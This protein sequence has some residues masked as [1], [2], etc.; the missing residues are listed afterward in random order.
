[1]RERRS[2]DEIR[3]Q[4]SGPS[5]PCDV[6]GFCGQ[7]FAKHGASV[8]WNWHCMDQPIVMQALAVAD[9]LPAE[10]DLKARKLAVAIEQ[11]SCAA[12]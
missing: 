9:S 5:A 10:G 3:D 2:L 1:M 11:A 12:F 4:C 8:S 7:A 6:L